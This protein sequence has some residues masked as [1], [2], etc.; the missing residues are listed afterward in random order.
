VKS[1]RN[2]RS[3]LAVS[4]MSSLAVVVSPA[5]REQRPTPA[6]EGETERIT[7]AQTQASCSFAV[8]KNVYDGPEWWGTITFKNLGPSAASS[9]SVEF[10]VPPGAHC[11]A[12]PESI[13]AGA[14]LSPLTATGNPRRTVS[15]HC[16]FTWSGT[17]LASGAS[18][19]FNYSTDS[20]SFTAAMS[21]VVNDTVC[22]GAAPPCAP[23]VI[24]K[25]TYNGSEWW[26]TVTF[27]N[28][29]AFPS[30]NKL[31]VEFDNPS[32]VH[33]TAEP[34][35]VPAGATLTPLTSTGNPRRTV[36][37][38]CVFTWADTTALAPGQSKTF[39]YSRDSQNG[40]V[41][42]NLIAVDRCVVEQIQEEP[43]GESEGLF[44]PEGE[45]QDP[46]SDDF[47]PI[48]PNPSEFPDPSEGT[49][50]PEV[51]GH[52]TPEVDPE[53]VVG[54]LVQP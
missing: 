33:C 44:K 6:G 53:L 30:S 23:L 45:P 5:C 49:G 27:K 13:P 3:L 36:S 14:T 18:K 52:F 11:T 32:G 25:N 35:S 20:Q 37:N 10:D 4:L 51:G 22:G 39:N 19:T 42:A 9:F 12:E 2:R 40:A 47:I 38:H 24:T 17:T 28:N 54:E 8:T 29:G 26:G 46:N 1:S 34:E 41:A 50:L 31:V 48:P 21:V 43:I 15:N 7:S 16:I